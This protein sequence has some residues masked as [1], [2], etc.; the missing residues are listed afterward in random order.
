MLVGGYD[1]AR[2]GCRWGGEDTD[3]IK[4]FQQGGL[5]VH[6][7][8]VEGFVRRQHTRVHRYKE[9]RTVN[10]YPEEDPLLPYTVVEELSSINLQDVAGAAHPH[11]RHLAREGSI[12]NVHHASRNGLT[13]STIRQVTEV[14]RHFGTGFSKTSLE[15][16]RG[17]QM[18]VQR[19]VLEVRFTSG[20]Q[21]LEFLLFMELATNDRM[22][23][24]SVQVQG[25]NEEQQVTMEYA[26][27][28]RGWRG[29][30]GLCGDPAK[31]IGTTERCDMDSA[32]P[33]CSSAGRCGIACDC[34]GCED[35]RAT[36][37]SSRVPNHHWTLTG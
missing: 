35:P 22:R 13:L 16:P 23:L 26:H 2:W 19:E 21:S 17:G 34:E 7:D 27:H 28:A 8:E 37:V 25:R 12:S 30:T 14:I 11:V 24:L 20:P 5:L 1:A 3:L 15:D 32:A 18:Q 36:F 33:C 10:Q 9:Q 6:R 31:T 4:K 29:D